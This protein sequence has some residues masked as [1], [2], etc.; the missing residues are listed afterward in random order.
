M[1]FTTEMIQLFAVVLG[2]DSERVSEM[3]LREGVM[4]FV[5]ITE[6]NRK[7]LSDLSIVRSHDS[8]SE[9]TALRERVEG[10]LQS[11]GIFPEAPKESD[12]NTGIS[13][14][15]E[16]EKQFIDKIDGQRESIRERQR[17]I[18]QEILKLEDIK[19]QV[20]LYG[21][22]ISDV[23]FTT[24]HSFLQVQTGRISVSNI[25]KLND[26]LKGFPSVSIA[27]GEELEMAHYLLI[28]MKR[29]CV[30][31]NKIL[32][33][34]GWTAIEL[35]EEVKSVKADVFNEISTKLGTLTEE[36]KK[37]EKKVR[38]LVKDQEKPLRESWVNLRV[39]ELLY[40]IKANFKS[41]A[42]TV[43][44]TG[45]LPLSKKNNL[46][47]GIRKACGNRCYMEWHHPGGR[48]IV[49]D[50][51]PVQ[52][53]NPKTF[54]PFEMLVSNFGIPKYSTIDPTPIVM[55]MYLIMFGL[56]FAD[57]G[58]GAVLVIAG[59]LGMRYFKAI[60]E[61]QG[62]YKISWLV[63]WCG[64]SSIFF[65]T[66]FASFFGVI[67]FEPIWFDYHGI[68]TGHKVEDTAINSI[69]DILAITLYFGIAVILI[70][71]TFNWINLVRTRQWTELFFDRGGIFGA[72]IYVGGLFVSIYMFNHDYKKLPPGMTTFWLVELP[73]LLLFLKE[74]IHFFQ[75][76]EHPE[77]EQPGAGKF[78]PFTVV[79]W[80]IMWVVEL[81]EIFS[82]YLA[83]TLSFM[84]VAGL[85]MAHVILMFSFFQIADMTS[86]VF[87]IV[88]L[89]LGNI[90]VIS[91]EGLS[92]GVQALR[93]SYYEFFSKFFHGTGKLYTPISLNSA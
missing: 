87:S 62:Y 60:P 24:R 22:G 93:L 33:Q 54:A 32:N 74:P 44:F 66:L 30:Q 7:E 79:F 89:I 90:L 52:L 80:V 40:K 58:H 1:I 63:V 23:P 10:L 85:G 11:A 9:I 2:R 27:L 48:E 75:H 8:I 53:K 50:E 56:M 15:V 4:Q 17:S 41:S 29:D 70:G 20:N 46:T 36:Q 43:V 16:N 39:T 18:Q 72:W 88:I 26:G 61:K 19:R 81:I 57:I 21:L 45:W 25:K 69:N 28:S 83:N 13:V 47:E 67:I 78:N 42:R 51:V 38:D 37:L 82:G 73:V 12:L 71:L 68:L 76:K 14:V 5:N 84:R 77:S 35:P 59:I 34:S 86:G 49:N 6:I 3:L 92:A 64:L 31:I 65:G 91:L 55:P